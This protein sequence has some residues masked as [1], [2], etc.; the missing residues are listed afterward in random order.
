MAI[1]KAIHVRYLKPTNTKPA[2]YIARANGVR[3]IMQRDYSQGDYEIAR[4][5][6]ELADR[7]GWVGLWRAGTM[8]D[9]SS[10]FVHSGGEDECLVYTQGVQH[11][12]EW[13]FVKA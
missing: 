12:G 13:F 8:P 3:H 1:Y 6:Y 10:V 7:L 11:M 5:A 2:R 9:G 4:C